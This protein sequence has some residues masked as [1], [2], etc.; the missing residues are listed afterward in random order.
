MLPSIGEA[1]RKVGSRL[2][3]AAQDDGVDVKLGVV[4]FG[5][6]ATEIR[7]LTSYTLGDSVDGI[8]DELSDVDGLEG[9]T[10]YIAGL[11][12]ATRMFD[13]QA[14]ISCRIL[15][16]FTDGFFDLPPD[17]SPNVSVAKRQQEADLL[18]DAVCG[19]GELA[20]KLSSRSIQ[21]FAVLLKPGTTEKWEQWF[22]GPDS[23]RY[24]ELHAGLSAMQAITGDGEI[25]A[26]PISD[27]SPLQECINEIQDNASLGGEVLVGSQQLPG[28]LFTLLSGAIGGDDL[29]K[30]P[31]SVT[32][33]DVVT[34][35]ESSDGLPAGVMFSRLF[36]TAL[37]GEIG[38][39]NAVN[40]AG[41]PRPLSHLRRP[42]SLTVT[43]L[44]I[45]LQAGSS[46]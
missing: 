5:E 24:P 44:R 14:D 46:R 41:S 40:F 21:T 2:Q 37:E 15:L 32:A 17:D 31:T 1:I 8:A 43:K 22:R 23:N 36:V 18:T 4:T 27:Y 26:L 7:P 39:V 25:S 29:I 13:S 45:Y 19:T 12:A 35:P 6:N 38:S 20:S 11:E 33:G 10:D 34:V 42:T 16:W 30:C 9:F 28:V 3:L